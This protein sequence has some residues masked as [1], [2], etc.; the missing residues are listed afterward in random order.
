MAAELFSDGRQ[1][2]WI[3]HCYRLLPWFKSQRRARIP[4]NFGIDMGLHVVGSLAQEF[5]LGKF[6]SRGK[7]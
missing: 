7:H 4:E 2:N 5:L 1:S 3:F 6:T